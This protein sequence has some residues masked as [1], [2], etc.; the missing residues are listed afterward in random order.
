MKGVKKNFQK[1]IDIMQKRGIILTEHGKRI[2]PRIGIGLLSERAETVTRRG[3]LFSGTERDP[4]RMSEQNR[5]ESCNSANDRQESSSNAKNPPDLEQKAEKT[6]QKQ[7]DSVALVRQAQA[8]DENAYATLCSDYAA[9]IEASVKKFVAAG[10]PEQDVRSDALEAFCKAIAHFDTGQTDVTFGLYA[11]ICIGNRLTDALRAFR[12][13]REPVSLDGLDP[14]ALRAGE[15]SDPTHYILEEERFA[16]LCRKTEAVLSP[17][18]R[19]IWML[20]ISG[21]TAPQIAKRLG[22]DRKSVEN[23]LFRARKKLRKC[24]SDS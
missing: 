18:E 2:T 21:L 22:V 7:A 20:F 24:F 17:G 9:L 8:G 10:L 19:K 5:Q 14:D 6:D 15:E 13:V 16:D 23:A 3:I 4:N 12:R 1:S 11:R